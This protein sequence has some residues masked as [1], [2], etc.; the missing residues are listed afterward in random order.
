[1]YELD[2]FV[3]LLNLAARLNFPGNQTPVGTIGSCWWSF[4]K[5]HWLCVRVGVGLL[6]SE[7]GPVPA[8]FLIRFKRAQRML[9]I[10][11]TRW[12]TEWLWLRFQADW[13]HPQWANVDPSVFGIVI[14][15]VTFFIGNLGSTRSTSIVDLFLDIHLIY[16][17]IFTCFFSLHRSNQVHKNVGKFIEQG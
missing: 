12:W 11:T 4:A 2:W 3:K 7:R 13:C 17:L 15:F 9:W 10:C 6:T 1:M 5:E 14:S 8:L 16:F